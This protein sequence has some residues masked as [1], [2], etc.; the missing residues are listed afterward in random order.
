M[1]IR[2]N[3]HWTEDYARQVL[4][5]G[6]REGKSITALA[7]EQGVSPQR[8]YWWKKR[9]RDEDV[10]GR[11]SFV[12]VSITAPRQ[13]QPFAVQTRSGRSVAVW[14]GFDAAELAR[15]LAV[16]EGEKC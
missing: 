7:R 14:P 13:A 15:L 3:Q 6:E 11:S 5:R 8:L 16:V 1:N 2:K 10:R 9:L 12:E 4:A